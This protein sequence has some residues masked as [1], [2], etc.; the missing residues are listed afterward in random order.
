MIDILRLN[1]EV[2]S[3]IATQDAD[4]ERMETEITN[5]K[6]KLYDDMMRD[7][8]QMENIEKQ[9]LG[10]EAMY[11]YTDIDALEYGSSKNWKY[12][13]KFSDGYIIVEAG[14]IDEMPRVL[15]ERLRK[16]KTPDLNARCISDLIAQW[17]PQLPIFKRR[18]EEKCVEYIKKKAENANAR[19]DSALARYE[20]SGCGTAS[21]D[22]WTLI[23]SC[24]KDDHD[25]SYYCDFPEEGDYIATIRIETPRDLEIAYASYGGWPYQ[26]YKENDP[27]TRI[28][29]GCFEP[30]EAAEEIV[31]A[32]VKCNG[33]CKTCFYNKVRENDDFWE[34]YKPKGCTK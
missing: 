34:K 25:L 20:H 19:Y 12:A 8:E 10:S 30:S 9:V 14:V 31:I 15:S 27:T 21:A 7:L 1:E 29:S 5:Y 2:E 18:F 22:A 17:K 23:I 3:L 26:L 13:I 32:G 28:G 11:V 24:E 33:C 16:G 4:I 6:Q